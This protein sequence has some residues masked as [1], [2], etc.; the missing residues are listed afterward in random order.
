MAKLY[1]NRK[2]LFLFLYLK[3][4]GGTGGIEKFNRAMMKALENRE[5][6]LKEE[7]L[8]YSAYDQ[9]PDNQYYS[10]NN[11]K[12]F[13]IQKV[14]FT[15]ESIVQGL[16]AET[17]LISHINLALIAL[18]LQFLKPKQKQ[19]LI[20]HGI[21]VWGELSWLKRKLLQSR[22]NILSVSNFTRNV[23]LTK[24]Q[25][26]ADK[27]SIFR[28]TLDPYFN[29][30]I[31]LT[32]IQSLRKQYNIPLDAQILMTIARLKNY[33]KAK[34]YDKV[35]RILGELINKN[36]NIYYIL[37]GKYSE[38]EHAR[39]MRLAAECQVADRIIL[40]GFIQD[41]DMPAHYKL[42][43]LFIMPSTKEGF[44]IVFIE[45]MACGT[46]VVAGNKDGSPDTILHDSLG[47]L[48]DPDNLMEIL[49][50]SLYWLEKGKEGV[51]N[52]SHLVWDTF[53][54]EKFSHNVRQL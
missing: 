36:K 42:A 6:Q 4:F 2:I 37:A 47:S 43:D 30:D 52:S 50:A 35:I 17:L 33:E 16:R 51:A 39:I 29:P 45:S 22:I 13:S 10:G 3:A 12:G 19:I 5:S 53:G 28:N 1:P 49:T 25:V 38:D 31:D 48:V 26:P 27:V 11:F 32:T 41:A 18:I 40:P 7:I 24:H 46:P 21:E 15:L 20:T 34:G 44:G 54:F 14:Q 23:L 9:I 8:I